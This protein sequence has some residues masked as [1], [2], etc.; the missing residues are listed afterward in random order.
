M[1]EDRASDPAPATSPP[2]Q[3]G[4]ADAFVCETCGAP[5]GRG[6]RFCSQPCWHQWQREHPPRLER[7]EPTHEEVMAE[8]R[9][10]Y[11]RA[12]KEATA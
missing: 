8:M 2:A 9:E 12:R 11:A 3:P 5:L 10:A 4:T 7:E 1:S 6:Y